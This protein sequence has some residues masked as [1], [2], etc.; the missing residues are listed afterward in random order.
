M[1]SKVISSEKELS[2]SQKERWIIDHFAVAYGNSVKGHWRVLRKTRP[3]RPDFLLGG[4]DGQIRHVEV[5]EL[6]ESPSKEVGRQRSLQK[7]FSRLLRSD[8]RGHRFRGLVLVFQKYNFPGGRELDTHVLKL[9]RQLNELLDTKGVDTAWEATISID[10]HG[11]HVG[12]SPSRTNGPQRMTWMFGSQ[13]VVEAD[14]EAY[15][16]GLRERIAGKAKK[17][18]RVDHETLLVIYDNS[19][20]SIFVNDVKKEIVPALGRQ[21]KGVFAE[22]WLLTSDGGMAF[23][24]L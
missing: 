6:L 15:V 17:T 1:T 12:H 23:P 22:V 16:R 20:Y 21:S 9:V 5:T 19:H 3:P 4:E 13:G 18:Y 14:E 11:V 2:K 24:L 10:W 7:R 8:L